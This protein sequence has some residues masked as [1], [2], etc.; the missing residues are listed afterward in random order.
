MRGAE[1]RLKQNQ[2]KFLEEHEDRSLEHSSG[3][4]QGQLDHGDMTMFT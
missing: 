2:Q 3:E 1:I 4:Q